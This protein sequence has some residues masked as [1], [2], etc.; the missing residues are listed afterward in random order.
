SRVALD[1][2][3]EVANRGYKGATKKIT[4]EFVNKLAA[5]V[6]ARESAIAKIEE[7]L[8]PG[9]RQ[10][11]EEAML[12]KKRQPAVLKAM[13]VVPGCLA[14]RDDGADTLVA[15]DGRV[16]TTQEG[17][18]ILDVPRR[19]DELWAGVI[20]KIVLKDKSAKGA[21]KT[22]L[23]SI[24]PARISNKPTKDEGRSSALKKSVSN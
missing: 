6:G 14:F 19:C 5:I 11:N 2:R 17:D 20:K 23:K 9:T 10:R 21:T 3:Q 16:L 18:E 24:P 22:R 12:V 4:R 15:L 13:K 8:F 1:E 7:A